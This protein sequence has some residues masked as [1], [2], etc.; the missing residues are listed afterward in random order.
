MV[1][2]R[3]AVTN[4]GNAIRAVNTQDRKNAIKAARNASQA[5]AAD[6]AATD[7]RRAEYIDLWDLANEAG[8]RGLATT[9]AAAVKTAVCAAVVRERHASGGAGGYVWNH[10]GAH[11]L[12]IYYPPSESSSAFSSYVA[13]TIY[14][15]SQGEDGTWDEFLNWA[16]PSPDAR[17]GMSANRATIKLLGGDA[18]ADK[19]A[20][21]LPIVLRLRH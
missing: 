6:M 12:S 10:S 14:Q 13:P 7:Y 4:F 1:N 18:Y 8:S 16:L 9:Q 3:N 5:F 2:V 21:Y 17:R 15:M 19:P 11:G 20:V